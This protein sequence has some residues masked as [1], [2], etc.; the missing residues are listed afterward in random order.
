MGTVTEIANFFNFSPKRQSVLDE[1][2]ME[3]CPQSKIHKLKD[4]C[5]T[6]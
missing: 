5:R 1:K 6:R 3:L 2:I 4:L